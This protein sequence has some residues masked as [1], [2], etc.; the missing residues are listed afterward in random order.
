MTTVRNQEVIYITDPVACTVSIV[1]MS[2]NQVAATLFVGGFSFYLDG[3]NFLASCQLDDRY[4]ITAAICYI[5]IDVI[6]NRRKGYS[7]WFFLY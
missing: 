3:E 7:F 5:S 6:I 2:T 4:G 1:E